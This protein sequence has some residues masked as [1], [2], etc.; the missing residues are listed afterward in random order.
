ML[1]SDEY[2]D[3][4]LLSL[5]IEILHLIYV[6]YFSSLSAQV[7]AQD[8]SG[9]PCN[10]LDGLPLLRVCKFVNDTANP[11]V[12]LINLT[13]DITC[14]VDYPNPETELGK[15]ILKEVQRRCTHL[16][17]TE[18]DRE[19]PAILNWQ[20]AF[21]RLTHVVQYDYW[22][23]HHSE[24]SFELTIKSLRAWKDG[25]NDSAICLRLRKDALDSL[26]IL[27]E[28][29]A[30]PRIQKHVRIE[31]AFHVDL[32]DRDW[33]DGVIVSLHATLKLESSAL[34]DASVLANLC[35]D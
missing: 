15:G 12:D 18:S 3:R 17:I 19:L 21:P 13:F 4:T 26:H 14:C 23:Q 35:G 27:T 5:P 29:F 6:H 7:V 25:A 1:H 31:R 34:L 20:T 9:L 10:G 33:K 22:F 8:G 11:F 28:L 32:S 30:V 24:P 2:S 16:M